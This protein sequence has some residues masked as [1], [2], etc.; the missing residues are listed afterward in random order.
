MTLQ[1][2]HR[3]R[4]RPL[5]AQ[6]FSPRTALD[7]EDPAETTPQQFIFDGHSVSHRHDTPPTWQK[8]GEEILDPFPFDISFD[9][10]PPPPDEFVYH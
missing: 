10:M 4:P 3:N 9:D 2:L 5:L 1:E 8:E 7:V 6:S